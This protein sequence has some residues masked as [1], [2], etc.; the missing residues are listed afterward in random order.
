MPY[1]VVPTGRHLGAASAPL[2]REE[3]VVDVK[4]YK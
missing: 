1:A 4:C 3:V 2:R